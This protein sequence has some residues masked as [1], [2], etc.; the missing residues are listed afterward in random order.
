MECCSLFLSLP[1]CSLQERSSDKETSEA[2][3]RRDSPHDDSSSS[4]SPQPDTKVT[5]TFVACNALT[6]MKDCHT[7]QGL[8]SLDF[9]SSM[10]SSGLE[11]SKVVSSGLEWSGVVLCGACI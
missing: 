10:A 8:V 1:P 9:S 7:K 2:K 4:A 6:D 3:R 11:W 5:A